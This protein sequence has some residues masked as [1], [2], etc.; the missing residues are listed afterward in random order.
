VVLFIYHR[1]KEKKEKI[2]RESTS[3]S[4]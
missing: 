4:F 1:L 2:Q 3:L